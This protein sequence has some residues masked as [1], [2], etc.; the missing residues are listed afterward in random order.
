MGLRLVSRRQRSSLCLPLPMNNPF[1]HRV[2]FYRVSDTGQADYHAHQPSTYEWRKR[3]DSALH[4]IGLR[5]FGNTLPRVL[6]DFSK[7]RVIEKSIFNMSNIRLPGLYR[8][9]RTIL[10]Q[11]VQAKQFVGIGVSTVAG[12]GTVHCLVHNGLLSISNF[13]PL[14]IGRKSEICSSIGSFFVR[15]IRTHGIS[16]D[17][18]L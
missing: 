5:S 18:Q 13:I 15:S 12:I 4:R 3:F 7:Q 9:V 11:S 17:C 6:G 2:Y 8:N 16:A 1:F 14:F 10:D